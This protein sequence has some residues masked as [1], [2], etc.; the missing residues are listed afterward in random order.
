MDQL[1]QL[2]GIARRPI[3]EKVQ[4]LIQKL[5]FPKHHLLDR[6]RLRTRN[7][8]FRNTRLEHPVAANG[9]PA[10]VAILVS[11]GIQHAQ[12]HMMRHGRQTPRMPVIGQL[13]LDI[14]GFFR[15]PILEILVGPADADPMLQPV[16]RI[17]VGQDHELGDT[18]IE[19]PERM[20][21][22]GQQRRQVDMPVEDR[23]QNG[24]TLCLIGQPLIVVKPPTNEN[25]PGRPARNQPFH[26]C[27]QHVQ[28]PGPRPLARVLFNHLFVDAW[29][30]RFR[31]GC[32]R[33]LVHL[34]QDKG[35]FRAYRKPVAH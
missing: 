19:P 17:A 22:I 16:P 32:A 33:Q 25:E 15:A 28:L 21:A 27:Q 29:F 1:L 23:V 34:I 2:L 26:I 13:V 24:A 12:M 18:V 14:C 11:F 7:R 30:G 3:G 6:L 5:L 8:T 10:R 9:P 20:A 4:E 31:I 35:D